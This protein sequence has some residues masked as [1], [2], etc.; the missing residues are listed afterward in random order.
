MNI[1]AEFDLSAKRIESKIIFD[2]RT[3]QPHQVKEVEE[4]SWRKMKNEKWFVYLD[5]ITKTIKKRK[6]SQTVED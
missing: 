2:V 3:F 5:C 1:N 6:L 4:W